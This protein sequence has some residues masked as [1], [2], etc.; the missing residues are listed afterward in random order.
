MSNTMTIRPRFSALFLAGSLAACSNDVVDLGGGTLSQQV[1]YD[2]RCAESPII[3]GDVT[4]TNQA[5]L[6]ALLGCE[7]IRGALSVRIFE[8]TDLTP[9]ADLRA[10]DGNLTLGEILPLSDGFSVAAIEAWRLELQ[11]V[12]AIAEAGWL[13]SLAGVESIERTGGLS[14]NYIGAPSLEAFESLRLVNG[15]VE[16]EISGSL[17]ISAAQNLVDLGGLENVRSFRALNVVDNPLLESLDGLRVGTTLDALTLQSNPR[18]SDIDALLP[19]TA[20]LYNVFI[21]DT[22]IT[23]VDGLA[24]LVDARQGLA[25]SSNPELTQADAL[26][27]LQ[28]ADFLVFEDCPKLERLPEFENLDGINGFKVMR[29]AALRSISLNFPNWN[30]FNIVDGVDVSIAAG[31][32]EIGDNQELESITFEAGFRAAQVLSVYRNASLARLDLG[33]LE[34]LDQLDIVGNPALTEVALGKLQTVDTLRVFG[35][36]QLSTSELRGVRT[37]ES[38][39]GLNAD[40]PPPAP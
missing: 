27:A 17:S 14:L 12:L 2:S 5:E 9:L 34:R 29:N 30:A 8:G 4:V 6:D 35:N 36:A 15:G 19:L 33:S 40:D 25:L 21:F 10:V 16:G 20:V 31:V 22:A 18:L 13:T 3:E 24:N 28:V 7:E 11:R 23:D 32:I 26:G 37:F 39:F 38:E 1:T